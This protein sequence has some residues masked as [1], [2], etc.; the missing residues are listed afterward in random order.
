LKY[1]DGKTLAAAKPRWQ[2]LQP[3]QSFR[4]SVA[5]SSGVRLKVG[6]PIGLVISLLNNNGL[7]FESLLTLGGNANAKRFVGF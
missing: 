1:K 7:F 2:F 3:N 4:I 5:S 6:A